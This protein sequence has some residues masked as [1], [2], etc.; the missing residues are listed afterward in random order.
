MAA[1]DWRAD[2][3]VL[4]RDLLAVVRDEPEEGA[5]IVEVKQQQALVVRQLEGDL[6]HPGLGIVELEDP[7]EQ[8]RADLADRR[9]YGMACLAVQV[10]EH[11][12]TGLVNVAFHS[13]LRDALSGS[14]RWGYRHVPGRR[15]RP[16]RLP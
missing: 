3:T 7:T 13:D 16:S 5:Q 10:P 4:G 14:S 11:H 2:E 12:R 15:H 9:A 1:T 8:A 6:K